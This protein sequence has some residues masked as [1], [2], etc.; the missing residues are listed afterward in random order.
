L[1]VSG[2]VCGARA[3]FGVPDAITT[4]LRNRLAGK[5]GFLGP[6][7][8]R[9]VPRGGPH[10]VGKPSVISFPIYDRYLLMNLDLGSCISRYA[11]CKKWYTVRCQSYHFGLFCPIMH[12]H[13]CLNA[14]TPTILK[15]DVCQGPFNLIPIQLHQQCRPP[16]VSTY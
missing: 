9:R 4:L 11:I 14:Q 15:P 13:Y 2:I 6:R 3:G 7:R 12:R 10:H 16:F 5:T 1:Q 8:R